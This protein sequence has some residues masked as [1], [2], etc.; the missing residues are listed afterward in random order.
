MTMWTFL[1]NLINFG[2]TKTP[3]VPLTLPKAND[4]WTTWTELKNPELKYI[5]IVMNLLE[6]T[7]AGCIDNSKII[8]MGL[9]VITLT[10]LVINFKLKNRELLMSRLDLVTMGNNFKI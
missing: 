4:W 6:I 3:Q 8:G 9:I 10:G 7:I 5:S 2:G 1:G